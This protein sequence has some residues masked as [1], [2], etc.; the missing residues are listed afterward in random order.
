MSQLKIPHAP[1]KSWCSQRN[2]FKNFLI[3]DID[4]VQYVNVLSLP[5]DFLSD[6]FS[7]FYCKN[8]VYNTNNIQNVC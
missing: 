8:A 6:I 5:Y 3:Y 7:L 1:T 2:N 4:I